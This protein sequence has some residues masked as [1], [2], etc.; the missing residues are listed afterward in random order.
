VS[1]DKIIPALLA[2]HGDIAAANLT[3]TPER[4]KQVDFSAPVYSDVSEIVVTVP[5]SPKIASIDDLSGKEVF[6]R[7]SSGYH[8][9][10]E[11]LNARFRKEGKSPMKLRPAPENL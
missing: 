10:L 8:E 3:I 1:R 2:G 9:H 7:R 5:S 11:Q 4:R 6:V